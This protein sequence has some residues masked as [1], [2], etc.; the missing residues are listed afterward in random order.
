MSQRAAHTSHGPKPYGSSS[1]LFILLQHLASGPSPSTCLLGACLFFL[2]FVPP[3]SWLPLSNGV[4]QVPQ[5][6]LSSP[7]STYLSPKSSS[8]SHRLGSL[9]YISPNFKTPHRFFLWT[10][11]LLFWLPLSHTEGVG[12][13][14]SA[15]SL[16]ALSATQVFLKPFSPFSLWCLSKHTS[17]QGTSRWTLHVVP[18]LLWC[19][20]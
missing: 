16:P 12:T 8:F 9:M 2:S 1:I 17:V 19:K 6:G 13:P 15:C 20:G 14:G 3:P 18:Q 10:L 5:W 11:F 7:S 4:S